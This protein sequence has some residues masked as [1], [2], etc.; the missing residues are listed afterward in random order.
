[1]GGGS[2]TVYALALYECVNN[3]T[4]RY[5]QI[6]FHC[7]LFFFVWFLLNDH[8]NTELETNPPFLAS[9][10]IFLVFL[11]IR[12]PLKVR[13]G[14]CKKKKESRLLDLH[15]IEKTSRNASMHAQ[16]YGTQIEHLTWIWACSTQIGPVAHRM[17]HAITKE[18]KKK[19][20]AQQVEHHEQSKEGKKTVW[21][22]VSMAI[23]TYIRNMCNCALYSVCHSSIWCQSV[24]IFLSV[25][26]LFASVVRF[27]SIFDILVVRATEKLPT[28]IL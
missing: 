23:K 9:I 14:L 24:L 11:I 1:M 3:V 2:W 12:T 5:K 26:D 22:A 16:S 28:V 13:P 18:K 10:I 21:F 15:R 20:I 25:S 4:W 17:F 6:L 27:Y 8:K 19:R 7:F